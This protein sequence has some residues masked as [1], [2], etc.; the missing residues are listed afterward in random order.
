MARLF[1]AAPA[2]DLP[3]VPKYN[4]CPTTQIHAVTGGAGAR[5]LI[6]M[7]WGFVPPWAKGP[8]DGPLMINARAETLAD[9]PAFRQ[10]ARE[11]RCLIPVSGFYE[12][13]RHA[14]GVRL[15]WYISPA[16]GDLFAFAG[17]WQ[18]YETGDG[19]AASCAIVTCAANEAMAR[20]HDR[21]P[22][23]IAKEDQALWLGEAG[24]GAARLMRPAPSTDLRMWRVSTE[25][26]SNRSHGPQLIAPQSAA[27]SAHAP[28]DDQS[29]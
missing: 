15:P 14:D 29:M 3:D 4:V 18:A 20:V 21:M 11:R 27:P 23:I 7:R 10:A 26:N 12:W 28:E 13:E 6:S 9:K 24:H 25:V 5:R 19:R 22:V 16:Q 2:N 8:G 17:V 1:G